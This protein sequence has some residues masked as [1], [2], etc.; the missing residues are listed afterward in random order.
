VTGPLPWLEDIVETLNDFLQ[1]EGM[2]PIETAQIMLALDKDLVV[3]RQPGEKY[4]VARS[5]LIRPEQFNELIA[6]LFVGGPSWVHANLDWME[7]GR[8]LVTIAVGAL[9]GNPRPSI[10]VSYEKRPVPI[11]D[12]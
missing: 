3:T 2:A 12:R 6:P 9:V 1:R 7:D 5:R 4:A 11:L 10:N 8:P